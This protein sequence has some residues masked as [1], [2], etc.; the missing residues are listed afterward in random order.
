[1]TL[2]KSETNEDTGEEEERTI[3]VAK[4]FVVFNLDQIDGIE[5]PD[6]QPTPVAE[7]F[8]PLLVGEALLARSGALIHEGVRRLFTL[9]ARMLLPCLIATALQKPALIMRR[10]PMS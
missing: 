7:G 3:P 6:A 4:S 1:M 8:D 9:L 2:T 5:A 10:P